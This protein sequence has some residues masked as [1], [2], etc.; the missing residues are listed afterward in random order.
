MRLFLGP[1]SDTLIYSL[2][3]SMAWKAAGIAPGIF[4]IFGKTLLRAQFAKSFSRARFT[5]DR[6]IL[7]D[8]ATFDGFI[9][10]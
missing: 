2:P 7:L 8:D 4:P 6:G 9:K 1:N 5:A 3:G 10:N